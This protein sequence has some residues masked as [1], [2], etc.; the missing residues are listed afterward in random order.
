LLAVDAGASVDV[1]EGT[2]PLPSDVGTTGDGSTTPRAD[3][4][5][6]EAVSHIEYVVRVILHGPFLHLLSNFLLCHI[7]N[8]EDV[9]PIVLLEVVP[10][11][12][13]RGQ[14]A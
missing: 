9:G 11:T 12:M 3:T 14:G 1:F 6:I 10:V 7:V 2:L 13:V 4:T 5:P 8:I